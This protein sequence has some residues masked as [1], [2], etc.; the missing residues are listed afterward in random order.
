MSSVGGKFTTQKRNLVTYIEPDQYELLRKLAKKHGR[1][2]SAEAALALLQHLESHQAE[3][4]LE[5][6]HLGES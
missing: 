3:L 5:Q 2:V 1:S 6:V 4:E